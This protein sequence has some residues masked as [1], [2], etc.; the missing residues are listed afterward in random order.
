MPSVCGEDDGIGSSTEGTADVVSLSAR[1]FQVRS[2]SIRIRA[3][4]GTYDS[5]KVP[6]STCVGIWYLEGYI[7][8]RN[9]P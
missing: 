1:K 3:H 6:I 8:P 4:P 7:R 9:L 5:S 2:Y